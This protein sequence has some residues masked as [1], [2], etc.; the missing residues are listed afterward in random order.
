MSL[1]TCDWTTALG[2]SRVSWVLNR[3]NISSSHQGFHPPT[4]SCLNQN[5][6]NIATSSTSW[7]HG[8]HQLLGDLPRCPCLPQATPQSRWPGHKTLEGVTRCS[9]ICSS[10]FTCIL[11]CRHWAFPELTSPQPKGSPVTLWQWLIAGS[12]NFLMQGLCW[13]CGRGWDKYTR[14]DG[15][16]L[17]LVSRYSGWGG[18]ITSYCTV[19]RL[20]LCM[21]TR[22]DKNPGT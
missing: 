9:V 10:V 4:F 18:R 2:P 15:A 14:G 3:I 6:Q 11:W 1:V 13:G 22:A 19:F 17:M 7:H 16:R 12:C 21:Q 20:V 5:S 8:F